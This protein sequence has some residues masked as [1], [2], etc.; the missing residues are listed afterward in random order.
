[1]AMEISTA[2]KTRQVLPVL[3]DGK[4]C[5]LKHLQR[6]QGLNLNT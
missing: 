4:T 3:W 1:M 5:P 2:S 6:F